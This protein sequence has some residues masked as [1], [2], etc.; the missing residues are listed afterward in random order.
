M[1]IKLPTCVAMSSKRR[2]SDLNVTGL[3]PPVTKEISVMCSWS[4]AQISSW[5]LI[6]LRN[7]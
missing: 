1:S 7:K 5:I 4:I 6:Y 2:T 3:R